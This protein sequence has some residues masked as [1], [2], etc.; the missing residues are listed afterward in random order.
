MFHA[1]D[2]L[3]FERRTYPDEI[4]GRDILG[5]SICVVVARGATSIL[6]DAGGEQSI[7]SGIPVLFS[8]NLSPEEF[9]SIMASMSRRGESTDTF[10]EALE[11]LTRAP[12]E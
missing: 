10:H 6:Y 4:N 3:F 5:G 9:A 7:H 12:K 8:V 1:R 2:G 11:F